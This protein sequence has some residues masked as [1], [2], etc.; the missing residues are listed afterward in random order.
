MARVKSNPKKRAASETEVITK[1]VRKDFIPK[2]IKKEL[3][4]VEDDYASFQLAGG[5]SIFHVNLVPRGTSCN[6]RVGR[7]I[8]M[9]SFQLKGYSV[10]TDACAYQ[11]MLIY[12]K[13][14]IGGLPA[15]S[16][17]FYGTINGLNLPNKTNQDRFV[18][19]KRWEG[20]M[21]KATLDEKPDHFSDYVKIPEECSLTAWDQNNTLGNIGDIKQGGLYLVGMSTL[22]S[23]YP[24]L[25]CS[26]RLQFYDD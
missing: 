7:S 2:G 3:H 14:P 11:F 4:W 24:T 10:P 22:A 18:V 15:V 1:K 6:E 8:K 5:G 26:Y 9:K 25:N 19:I 12:D 13:R 23:G 20:T 16:D 21:G 17:I